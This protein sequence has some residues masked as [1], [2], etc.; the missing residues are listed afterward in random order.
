[1]T[2]ERPE[3]EYEQLKSELINN[4]QL[5]QVERRQ[6]LILA[7]I[8]Y[9]DPADREK[10]DGLIEELRS[11][12]GKESDVHAGDSFDWFGQEWDGH[13]RLGSSNRDWDGHPR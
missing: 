13:P 5:T 1:M 11:V 12:T 2:I 9:C 3:N 6:L 7:E 4:S 10:M 8:V